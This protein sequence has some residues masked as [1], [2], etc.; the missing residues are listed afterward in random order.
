MAQIHASGKYMNKYVIAIIIL[1][2]AGIIFFRQTHLVSP[3]CP[4]TKLYDF[5]QKVETKEEAIKL[6][7]Q[8]FSKENGYPSF[9]DDKV[10]ENKDSKEKYIY[11]SE[12]GYPGIGGGVLYDNGKLV[13]KGYCK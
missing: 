6:F 8:F 1:T 11:M 7:K 9:Y 12:Y 2:A 13:R 4:K 3:I 10:Y 5:N